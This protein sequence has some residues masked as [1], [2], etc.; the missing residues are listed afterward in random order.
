MIA[1]VI[2]DTLLQ[3]RKTAVNK[4]KDIKVLLKHV[5]LLSI[6]VFVVMT[7]F[8]NSIE[9][10]VLFVFAN[11][12]THMIIDWNIWNQYEFSVVSRL[13]KWRKAEA[14]DL[15]SFDKIP[16]W[17]TQPGAKRLTE[18]AT[19]QHIVT[20][21]KYARDPWFFHTIVIDQM[22]HI[23]TFIGLLLTGVFI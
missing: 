7:L 12:V 15:I 4:S 16:W 9:A 22:L 17:A 1:H 20:E 18:V 3:D 19:P 11:A 21:R 6:P 23:L 2:G 10:L 13:N 14:D 8:A 5:G